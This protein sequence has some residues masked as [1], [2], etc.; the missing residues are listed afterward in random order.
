MTQPSPMSTPAPWNLVAPAYAEEVVPMF[1]A[2]ATEALRLAQS[3]AGARVVDVAC[4]PGT[5]AVLAARKGHPVDAI[6]FA[7]GM[8]E[9]L[10]ARTQALGIANVHGHLGDGQALPFEDGVF[11]AAFSMFGLMF[12]PDRAK[13]FAEL[14]RVLAPGARAVVSSWTPLEATPV[15]AA[16]FGALREAMGKLFGPGGPQPGSHDMPLTT[17]EACRSEMSTAFRDVTIHRVPYTHR[18][19]SADAFWDSL[20]RTMAPITLMKKSLGDKF[21]PLDDAARE[22]IRRTVGDGVADV[23]LTAWLSVGTAR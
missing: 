3:P 14:R 21:A 17:E 13:G 5:L 20:V 23:T 7:P 6:D 16:M 9:Q 22:A 15:M 18:Y 12:F 2:F 10:E 4:G 19:A 1:E 11:G 8:I